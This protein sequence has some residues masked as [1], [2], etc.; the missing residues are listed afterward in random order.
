MQNKLK[1]LLTI[2]TALAITESAY[3]QNNYYLGFS[4][5]V[6]IPLQSTFKIAG[7]DEATN[8]DTKMPVK[9]KKSAMSTITFGY[10]IAEGTA[11]E[12]AADFKF[13]YPMKLVFPESLGAINTKAT[14]AIYMVNVVYDL[15]KQGEVTPYFMAGLGLADV[16]LKS[17]NEKAQV[18]VLEKNHRKAMAFQIGLGARYPLNE[19]LELDF[20]AKIQGI[21]KIRLRYQK[22]NT[23]TGVM[24]NKS[25]KQALAVAELVGGLR[26]R[27]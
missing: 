22:L 20:A 26:V 21:S 3:A 8:T 24:D 7:K 17:N 6:S 16:K 11:V 15:A 1:L 19:S 14:A 25:T 2:C 9:I 12:F 27:F 13:K 10:Q 4:G 18:F 23:K 5:G